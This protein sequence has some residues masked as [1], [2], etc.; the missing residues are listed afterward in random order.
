MLLRCAACDRDFE[1]SKWQRIRTR[2]CSANLPRKGFT[3]SFVCAGKVSASF[4]TPKQRYSLERLARCQLNAAVRNGTLKRPEERERC[5]RKPKPDRI[6]RTQIDGHHHDYTKPL[7][8]EWL[9]KFC[10]RAETPNAH[11]RKKNDTRVC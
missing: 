6:G 9:C 4:R 7:D 11:K 5:G 10:H 2:Y 1:A 8:V 3:C